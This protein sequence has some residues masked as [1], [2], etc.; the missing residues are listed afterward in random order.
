MSAPCCWFVCLGLVKLIWKSLFWGLLLLGGSR[1]KQRVKSF[2]GFRGSQRDQIKYLRRHANQRTSDFRALFSCRLPS[3]I[4]NHRGR[5]S[6]THLEDVCACGR[7]NIIH[8]LINYEYK[9]LIPV[10]NAK[11]KCF[12]GNHFPTTTHKSQSPSKR[13]SGGRMRVSGCV[14]H[15]IYRQQFNTIEQQPQPPPRQEQQQREEKVST[16]NK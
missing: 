15:P 3:V 2:T 14:V 13:G 6:R 1:H 16:I 4:G 7:Y 5:N 12:Q 9:N 11:K 8:P 10:A